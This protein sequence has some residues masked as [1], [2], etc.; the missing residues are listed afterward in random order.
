MN[1]TILQLAFAIHHGRGMYALLLGSGISR[2]AGIPTGWEITK[3]MIRQVAALKGQENVPSFEEWYR[4]EYSEEPEYD[5]VLARLGSTP[6][7]RNR[8]IKQFFEPTEE[9]LEEGIKQPTPA[10]H[11]IAW[12]VKHGYVRV[13][14]TTNFDQLLENALR[15]VGVVPYI[16]KS[17][18]EFSSMT[19]LQHSDI[20]IIKIHGDYKDWQIKNTTEELAQYCDAANICLT[21]IFSEY[22]LII[23]GWSGD[24]DTA[25]RGLLMQDAST[26]PK[27]GT[28][29]AYKS[30]LTD[31]AKSVVDHRNVSQVVIK[32]ANQFF[33]DLRET[34]ESLE[35]LSAKS[36][37]STAVLTQ[38][39]TRLLSDKKYVELE[40]LIRREINEA[41]ERFTS[42]EFQEQRSAIQTGPDGHFG[43]EQKMWQLYFNAVERVLAI[44]ST[45][46]WYGDENTTGLIIFG[47]ERFAE[48]PDDPSQRHHYFRLFPSLLAIYSAGIAMVE[49][50]HWRELAQ[51]LRSP[52]ISEV[53]RIARNVETNYMSAIVYLSEHLILETYYKR[54]NLFK[55]KKTSVVEEMARTDI[56]NLLQEYLPQ[57][58]LFERAFDLFEMLFCLVYIAMTNDNSNSV[59]TPTHATLFSR[60]GNYLVKHWEKMALDSHFLN[61]GLVADGIEG[62]SSI[63]KKYSAQNSGIDVRNYAHHFDM[64][65]SRGRNHGIYL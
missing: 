17:D 63:L 52:Q 32:D 24:Y 64:A 50:S 29:W 46:G 36:D 34:V 43:N 31:K 21:R 27:F 37:I 59:W 48:P 55:G 60:S 30:N 11:A 40:D 2:P 28:Y 49:R 54:T 58:S 57:N 16:V 62:I 47:I 51:I 45:L 20:T 1:D 9:E 19:P 23:C 4:S 56:A 38:R 13:I 61:S 6:I 42:A 5:A 53:N 25:L 33:T 44:V 10:H 3:E 39:V 22:G 65:E 15:E 7:D 8:I 12:L 26:G 18:D 35:R 41:Y 14:V